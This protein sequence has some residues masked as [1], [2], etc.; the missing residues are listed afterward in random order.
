MLSISHVEGPGKGSWAEMN[1]TC[2][3]RNGKCGAAVDL[4]SFSA[5]RADITNLSGHSFPLS[6]NMMSQDTDPGICELSVELIL[7]LIRA[8]I[9]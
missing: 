1:L 7:K 9:C 3:H 4:L 6:V 8:R 5:S 2:P